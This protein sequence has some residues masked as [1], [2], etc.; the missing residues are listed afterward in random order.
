MTDDGGTL[1]DTPREPRLWVFNLDAELELASAGP[2]Q[3]PGHVARA[4]SPALPF[5]RRAMAPQDAA[6]DAGGGHAGSSIGRAWCPTP[7]ALRRLT[8]A[9]ALPEAAPDMEILRRVNHK[10]FALEL[11]GGAPGARYVRDDAELRATLAETSV[12]AWLFKRPY[13]F[14]G[15]GQRRIRGLPSADDRRWLHDSLRKGGLVAEPWLELCR[16]LCVHGYIHRGG[17]VLLGRVCVQR[18]NAFRAWVATELLPPGA[19]DAART[20]QLS[21]QARAVAGALSAAGYFGPFGI[22]AYEFRTAS[23]A[24]RLN[25]LSEINARYGMGYAVGMAH[26][27][28]FI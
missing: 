15:R 18:T 3:T 9:G 13:G 23:G 28:A 1:S 7:W 27:L 10:R 21:N 6:L 4:L 22:D 16:E 2:Y 20:Q 19:L 8:R 14:A 24:T 26:A 17:R 11:G 25:P 5:A 12:A